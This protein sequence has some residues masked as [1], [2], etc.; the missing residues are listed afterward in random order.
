M[1]TATK[2]LFEKITVK[3]II[4]IG[5]AVRLLAV[6]FS[7]GYA[8]HDDHFEMPEL[9]FKWRDNISFLWTESNVHIFSLIYPG[10]M[11]I[12][13]RACNSIGVNKPEDLMLTVRLFHALFSLLSIYYAYLLTLRLTNNRVTARIVGLVMALFWIFPFLSVRNLREFFCIPFLIM[14]SYHIADPKL[15]NRPIFSAALLFAFSFCIRFQ[16]AFIPIGIG[17]CLLFK[18]KYLGKAILFGFACGTAYLI[19]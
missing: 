12:L 15:K 17:L 13:F 16:I 4:L 3:Q 5:L 9:V 10:I 7:P 18:K 6:F 19:T 14:A 8:F 1:M 2:Q 11:Y